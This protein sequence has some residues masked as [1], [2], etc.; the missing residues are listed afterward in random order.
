MQFLDKKY[1]TNWYLEKI[2]KR[3]KLENIQQELQCQ[4]KRKNTDRVRK[5]NI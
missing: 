2:M 1:N 4:G 3:K 5:I